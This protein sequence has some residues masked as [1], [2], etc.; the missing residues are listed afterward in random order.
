VREFFRLDPFAT[1]PEHENLRDLAPPKS[2]AFFSGRRR[3]HF[4][5]GDKSWFRCLGPS[6][7][8]VRKCRGAA[9]IT[10][11]VKLWSPPLELRR[12]GPKTH[13][14]YSKGHT[15]HCTLV[16]TTST[17][18]KETQKMKC[19]AYFLLLCG[20]VSSQAWGQSLPRHQTSVVMRCAALSCS[21]S[22]SSIRRA[23]PDVI[24][25]TF[26][27][28]PAGQ[29]VIRRANYEVKLGTFKPF[30]AT[31]PRLALR[32]VSQLVKEEKTELLLRKTDTFSS[33]AVIVLR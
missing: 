15:G 27:P 20:I 19:A 23:N 31:S 28:L 18:T 33:P 13:Q 2:I 8:G 29:S 1:A 22:V 17:L 3:A 24:L 21:S 12:N 6:R 11:Q 32:Q 5:V 16:L 26:K 30:P 25:G 10:F 7:D 9:F 4:R 14:C